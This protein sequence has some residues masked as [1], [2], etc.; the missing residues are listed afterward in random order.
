MALARVSWICYTYDAVWQRV[1]LERKKHEHHQIGYNRT[2]V[3]Y[4]TLFGHVARTSANPHMSTLRTDEGNHVPS[5]GEHVRR[6][7]M[8]GQQ[9]H[10]ANDA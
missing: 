4:I 9:M 7:G 2:D 5:F 6:R 8:V 1:N 3:R 10:R